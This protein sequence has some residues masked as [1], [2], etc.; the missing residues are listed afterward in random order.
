MSIEKIRDFIDS[1]NSNCEGYPV[2][3]DL[4]QDFQDL[5]ED[6]RINYMIGESAALAILIASRW[7]LDLSEDDSMDILMKLCR[8]YLEN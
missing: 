3:S 7:Q 8:E 1:L 2:L 4:I 5:C 6:H